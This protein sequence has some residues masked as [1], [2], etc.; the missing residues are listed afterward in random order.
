MF[1]DIRT[2]LKDP[3]S[4]ISRHQ[5]TGSD[6]HGLELLQHELPLLCYFAK[7]P[8]TRPHLPIFQQFFIARQGGEG[9]HRPGEPR[10]GAAERGRGHREL[11]EDRDTVQHAQ[12]ERPGDPVVIRSV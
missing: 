6:A 10:R 11:A 4:S 2:G 12:A 8:S 3:R 1:W 5:S 7:A 9:V